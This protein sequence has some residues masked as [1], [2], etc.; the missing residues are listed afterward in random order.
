MPSRGLLLNLSR[1]ATCL[2]SVASQVSR[3]EVP[4]A[5]GTHPLNEVER[6]ETGFTLDPQL[7]EKIQKKDVKI[8]VLGMGH[9]GLPT[10]LGLASLG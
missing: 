3:P 4:L 8:A 6:L 5:V 2:S 9:V 7:F 1:S 10:A